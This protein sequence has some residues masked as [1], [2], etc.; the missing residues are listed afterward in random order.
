MNVLGVGVEW[1]STAGTLDD[2][3]TVPPYMILYEQLRMSTKEKITFHF[4]SVFASPCLGLSH[5]RV[6]SLVRITLRGL[7]Y[8]A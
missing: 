5:F 7:S 2:Q 3:G 6:C 8:S 1:L 4:Y